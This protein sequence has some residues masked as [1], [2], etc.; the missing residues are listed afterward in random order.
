LLTDGEYPILKL[1][2]LSWK[3]LKSETT[4][5]ITRRI[6]QAKVKKATRSTQSIGDADAQL[7]KE[8]KTVR[9]MLADQAGI[10]PFM[11]FH[12]KHLLHMVNLKPKNETEFRQVQGV[13]ELKLKQYATPFLEKIVAHV[14]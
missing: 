10:P 1:T 3:I 7:L 5:N 6:I 9:K 14:K 8:L 2:P 13:G 4:I 11:I 12:D